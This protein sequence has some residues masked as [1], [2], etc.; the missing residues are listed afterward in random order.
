MTRSDWAFF[1]GAVLIS[2]LVIDT[3]VRVPGVSIA[4]A[5]GLLAMFGAWI[6]HDLTTGKSYHVRAGA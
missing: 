3:V 1:G 5:G 6:H 4:A 2:A